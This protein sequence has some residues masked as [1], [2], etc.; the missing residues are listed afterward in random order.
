V[1]DSNLDDLGSRKSGPELGREKTI[2]RKLPPLDVRM[3]MYEEVLTLRKKS[4]TLKEIINQVE[5]R[6]NFRLT[7]KTISDWIRGIRTPTGSA[8]TF[9]PKPTAELAYVIGVETGDAS[10]N[11]K[12]GYQYRIRLQAT[13]R[14]FVEA[15][16]QAMSKVLG[17]P[18]HSL[19]KGI[20]AKE[21]HVEFGSFLLHK[22]LLQELEQLKPFIEHD[23]RCVSAFLRGFFDSEGCVEKSGKLTGS[24]TESDLLK[25]VQLLLSKFFGIETTGPHPNTRKGSVMTRRGKSFLRNSDCYYVYVRRSSLITFYREIGLTIERK[26]SRL[27]KA[28]GLKQICDDER[29]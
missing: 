14:E 5:L 26:R 28:L 15:F 3:A 18:P 9:I 16:N 20:T 11:M 17:C 10:L 24:N 25:Y 2:R 6:Y 21:I 13:D 12:L 19:W 4:N 22:F 1:A 23:K 27:E 29:K 7:D 8:R